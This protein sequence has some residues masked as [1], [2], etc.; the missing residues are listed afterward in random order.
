MVVGAGAYARPVL[1]VDGDLPLRRKCL[2]TNGGMSSRPR[3][4]HIA[5]GLFHR[6]SLASIRPD[7][8]SLVRVAS[9]RSADSNF[10]TSDR[11]KRQ[12]ELIEQGADIPVAKPLRAGRS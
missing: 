3:P 12:L 7:P 8:A 5:G 2:L 10:A 1:V 9:G 6:F 11:Q 4:R